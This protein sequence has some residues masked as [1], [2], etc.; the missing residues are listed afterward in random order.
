VL[1][2][3]TGGGTGGHLYPALAIARALRAVRPGVDVLFVGARRGIEQHILPATEFPHALLDLHPYYRSARWRNW[4]TLRGLAGSW[5]ALG[6]L[7]AERPPALV[8]GTGG[9]ASSATLGWCVAHRRPYV[10]QEQNSFPGRTIRLFSRGAREIYLG[11]PECVPRLPATARARAVATGNPVQ[12]P[13]DPR[14]PRGDARRHWGFPGTS[15]RVLLVFGGSQGSSAINARVDAWLA[16]GLPADVYVIWATGISHF[17]QYAQR[18]SPQVVVREY[19]SPIAEAYAA[20]D[21]ALTR[22]GA[23]TTAELCAWAIPA[24]LIPLPTAAADHQTANARSLAAAG[25]A[26][27]LAERDATPERLGDEVRALLGDP[28]ALESLAAGARARARPDA[29]HQIAT[30]IAALLDRVAT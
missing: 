16:R 24:L 29:A 13:P 28:A 30:R 21:L 26:R 23:M 3:F 5:R 19:L 22:A 7:F 4:R 6:T 1:V 10:L 14:P 20:C 8:V 12:P 27:W 11:F 18:A 9:Y 17:A 2:V 15:G 25:A